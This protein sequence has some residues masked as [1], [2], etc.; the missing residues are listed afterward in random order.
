MSLQS[1]FSSD[2]FSLDLLLSYLSQS[3]SGSHCYFVSL[4]SRFRV[5][6]IDA[7]LPQLLA[8]A[9]NA[10]NPHP[11]SNLLLDSCEES[12]NLAFKLY[13]NCIAAT[14]DQLL[15][16]KESVSRLTQ[17]C[18]YAIVNGARSPV[19]HDFSPPHILQVNLPEDPGLCSTHKQVRAEVFTVSVQLATALCEVSVN[20]ATHETSSRDSVLREALMS[21]GKWLADERL[22]YSMNSSLYTQRLHRGAYLPIEFS[23][24]VEIEQIVGV[25][26]L[27]SFCYMTC[28]RVPYCVIVETVQLNDSGEE[29]ETAPHSLDLGNK[30]EEFTDLD[31]TLTEKSRAWGERWE[32]KA[33]R[34]SKSSQFSYLPSWR[35]RGIIAKGLDDLRQEHLAMQFIRTAQMIFAGSNTKLWLKPYDILVIS[36]NSGLIELVPDALSL[37]SIKKNCSD[38]TTLRCFFQRYLDLPFEDA[39]KN[40]VE[41]LA[42]YSLVCYLLNLKDRHNGNILLDRQ[43]HLIHIDFGF[44]LTNSPGKNF[45]FETAPF[46]LNEEFIEVMDGHGSFMYDYLKIL[47]FKGLLALRNHIDKLVL[48]IQVMLPGVHLPCF[49]KP[50][51]ALKQLKARFLLDKSDSE[52]YARIDELV[53]IASRSWTTEKYDNYQRY[54]N[55]I[56]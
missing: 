9:L 20:L 7:F 35:L 15:W 43:G 50:A 31:L 8:M 10:S 32:Q 37:D 34:I 52:V 54:S 19:P 6:Q 49:K 40:F 5:E 24:S 4:L 1:L 51:K 22:H 25:F 14:G 33:R 29:T 12:C 30:D 17:D 11:I 26:P 36:H 47:M 42:G 44:M 46:K 21:I 18:E 41:S 2:V 55:G 23:S 28:A 48:P 13:W 45:G 53:T 27:E 39:Q 16:Q 38:Y 3:Q 56:L